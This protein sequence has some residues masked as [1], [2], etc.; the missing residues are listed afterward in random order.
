MAVRVRRQLVGVGQAS[1]DAGVVACQDVVDGE[2]RGGEHFGGGHV[3]H[4]GLF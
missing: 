4:E 1:E 2:R 3:I